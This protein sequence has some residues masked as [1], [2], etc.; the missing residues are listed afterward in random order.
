[1]C[2]IS[3][4]ISKLCV[5]HTRKTIWSAPS[6]SKGMRKFAVPFLRMLRSALQCVWLQALRGNVLLDGLAECCKVM[7]HLEIAVE[8]GPVCPRGCKVDAVGDGIV[9][10]ILGD[11][12][13]VVHRLFG[14][15]QVVDLV[16]RICVWNN[17]PVEL[18]RLLVA[19]VR[20]LP[21]KG[22]KMTSGVE[23]IPLFHVCGVAIFITL[24]AAVDS[25]ALEEPGTG[26]LRFVTSVYFNLNAIRCAVIKNVCVHAIIC[27]LFAAFIQIRLLA[28]RAGQAVPGGLRNPSLGEVR[29]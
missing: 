11:E 1:M 9:S 18:S 21:T 15:R 23:D 2:Q 22:V 5:Y 27:G 10:S 17:L 20:Y 28:G 12:V 25:I 8:D 4:Q 14:E 26:E 7:L 16:P 3:L 24:V 29:N 13:G 19:K 6:V